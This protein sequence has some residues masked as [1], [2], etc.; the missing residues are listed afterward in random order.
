MS[1][2]MFLVPVAMLLAVGAL[3]VAAVQAIRGKPREARLAAVI[4]A[5]GLFC[6]GLG[7]AIAA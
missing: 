4:G 2:G 5:Y 1:L 7:Y 6:A 3:F